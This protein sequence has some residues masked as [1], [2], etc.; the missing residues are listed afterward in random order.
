MSD[1]VDPLWLVGAGGMAR[2]YAKVLAAQNRAFEVIGRGEASAATFTDKTGRPAHAGGLEAYL[3]RGTAPGTQA[4]VAIGVEDLAPACERLLAHGVKQ[5]LVEKP[6]G[7]DRGEIQQ[8][9]AH[10]KRTGAV[11]YVG[12]NRRFYA[13]TRRAREMIAEDGGVT[14]FTFEFTEWSH[15]IET[16]PL[17][18][19]IKKHWLLANSSHVIDHAFFLGGDPVELEARVAGSLSWHPSAAVFT[20]SGRSKSGALFSYHANWAAPGRWGVEVLTRKRRLIFR[21][22]E[23]LHITKLASVAITEEPLEDT[24]DR[25][26]KPGLY[27]QVAAFLGGDTQDLCTIDDQVA[28]CAHY[29]VI[30]GS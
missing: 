8:L 18:P 21:P 4:I 10:A 29:E 23:K 1:H 14:S 16:L 6:A 25:D 24:Y 13:S 30:G 11:I 17:S 7:L 26:F 20:G 28:A 3:A 9:A 19:R 15:E 22:M 2:E 27:R 12:Y 5:I